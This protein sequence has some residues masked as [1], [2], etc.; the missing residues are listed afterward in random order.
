MKE[1]LNLRGVIYILIG[2]ISWGF[3]GCCAQFLFENYD[4]NSYWLTEVRLVGSGIACLLITILR[5]SYRQELR[6]LLGE[7]KHLIRTCLYGVFGLTL[8]QLSYITGIRYTNAATTT[9]IQYTGPALVVVS[10]CLLQK[11]LP[12]FFE[13][14]ALFCAMC[15]TFFIATHGNIHHLEISEAGLF[16]CIVSAIAVAFYT[17][18]LGETGRV[19][20]IIVCNAVAML[21]GGV[22]VFF[23]F[24]IW[25]I[26]VSVDLA[27]MLAICGIVLVGTVLA[28]TFY[29]QA[30]AEIGPVNTSVIATIEPVSSAVISYFWLGTRFEMMDIFGFVLILSTIIWLTL[31]DRKVPA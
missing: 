10:V 2:G 4:I 14:L 7:K 8:C 19:F 25:T 29:L 31:N 5:S 18:M 20:P 1:K 11:R 13:I 27:G 24:R 12:R 26:E 21:F 3:S 17:L 16:W 9:V 23:A 22:I 6:R 30:V 15:G 28:F